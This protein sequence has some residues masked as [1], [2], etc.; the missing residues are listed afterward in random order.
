[1]LAGAFKVLDAMS[2]PDGA[3]AAARHEDTLRA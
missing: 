1:M 2:N 3:N